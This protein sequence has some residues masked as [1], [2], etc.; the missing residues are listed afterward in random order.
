MNVFTLTLSQ[1][2]RFVTMTDVRI[3]HQQTQDSFFFWDYLVH[4]IITNNKHNRTKDWSLQNPTQEQL[5]GILSRDFILRFMSNVGHLASVARVWDYLSKSRIFDPKSREI[6][7]KH[8]SISTVN[9]LRSVKIPTTIWP[10]SAAS[11]SY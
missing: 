1:F 10:A 9:L 3:Y 5:F 6:L 7:K 2:L 8:S 4:V 11:W